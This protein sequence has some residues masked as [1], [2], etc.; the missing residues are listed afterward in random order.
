MINEHYWA[1]LILLIAG[2]ASSSAYSVSETG[3]NFIANHEGIVL[4]LYDDLGQGK[5]DCTIGVGHLVHKGVCNG[6]DPSEQEFLNG[7]TKE[8]AIEL[9]RANVATAEEA[10]NRDVTV[11]LTQNQFDALVSFTY[12]LGEGNLKKLAEN[13][14]AGHYEA[15]PQE[16]NLYVNTKTE[17]NVPGLVIRRRDEGT[18][19][20]SDGLASGASKQVTLTLYIHDGSANGPVI[21]GAQVTGQDGSGNSFQATTDSKGYVT[22]EG[23]PGTW[24]FSVSADGYETNNWD[25]D[26]TE[27]CIKHAYFQK[28]EMSNRPQPQSVYAS[29]TQ[30]SE[31]N[32]AEFWYNQGESLYHQSNYD[33]AINAFDEAIRQDPNYA[34]AWGGKGAT[35]NAKSRYNEALDA[36]NNAIELDPMLASAWNNKGW[37]LYGLKKYNDALNIYDKAIEIDPQLSEAWGGRCAVLIASERYNEAIQDGEKAVELDPEEARIWHNYGAA[38]Y[39]SKRYDEAII[40]FGEAIKIDPEYA[41]AWQFKGLALKKCNMD[42]EAKIA[43]KKAAELGYSDI[44]SMYYLMS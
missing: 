13:L 29:S 35:F 22:I 3:L 16:M 7:I 6:Y 33:E 40:A 42:D 19:F 25:Q 44:F 9:F 24:S 43:F 4:E 2:S 20:Q 1:I 36:C 5:G 39:Y 41:E 11:P 23:N 27:D 31:A 10:V 37:S 12:N 15:V 30:S 18:L 17:K 14:N 26:I 34:E 38:L 28:T 32:D 21:P 8:H